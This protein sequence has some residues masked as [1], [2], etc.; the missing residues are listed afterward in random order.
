MPFPTI[1]KKKEKINDIKN[2]AIF[3]KIYH[4]ITFEYMKREIIN[5]FN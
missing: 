1:Q 3:I 5:K 2:F 4:K